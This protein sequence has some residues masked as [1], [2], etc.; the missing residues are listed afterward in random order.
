[1]RG[2]MTAPRNDWE[3]CKGCS[4]YRGGN[5]SRKCL[6]CGTYVEFLK[7]SRLRNPVHFKILPD[8]IMEA[9]PDGREMDV[10]DSIKR[11]PD[12]LAAI[13]TMRYYANLELKSIAGILRISVRQVS[14][15]LDVALNEIKRDI[16]F[17]SF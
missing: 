9:I 16:A 15:K 7:D 6:K 2:E 8:A 11:L 13:V 5:G 1:M 10:K 3:G 14:R 12:D 17:P 4:S